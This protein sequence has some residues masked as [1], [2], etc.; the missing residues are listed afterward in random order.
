M[1][2]QAQIVGIKEIIQTNT[3]TLVR[4]FKSVFLEI[5]PQHLQVLTD[6]ERW[7][8]NSCFVYLPCSPTDPVIWRQQHP[9]NQ[10]LS[11]L[12]TSFC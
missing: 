8:N 6:R 7:S 9:A 11:G 5:L 1:N 4:L 2:P 10:E 12:H 3:S